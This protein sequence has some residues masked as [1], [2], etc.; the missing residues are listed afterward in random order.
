MTETVRLILITPVR[1]E[2]SA[3][4]LRLPGASPRAV[5]AAG[6]RRRMDE[7]HREKKKYFV[8]LM[9]PRT[10]EHTGKTNVLE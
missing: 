9:T 6:R 2:P 1:L 10:E 4:V 7:R 5:M 8:A 3:A